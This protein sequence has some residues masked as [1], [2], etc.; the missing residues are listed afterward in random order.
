MS[1]EPKITIPYLHFSLTAFRDFIIA[2]DM[3]PYIVVKPIPGA[4]EVLDQYVK[5]GTV[6]LNLSPTACRSY[7]ISEEGYMIVEQRFNGKP[8]RAY[9]PVGWV[10][11]MF[12]RENPQIGMGFD[13]DIFG[14]PIND[15]KTTPSVFDTP[16]VETAEETSNVTPLRKSGL[17]VVK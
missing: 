6:T 16:V 8:H 14:T 1:Q 15:G 4:D 12:A 7:Q 17:S 2:N 13:G 11:A 9:I 5:E 3:T 10:L